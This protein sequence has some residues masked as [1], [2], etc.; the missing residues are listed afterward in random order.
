MTVMFA[1]ERSTL[2]VPYGVSDLDDF[3]DWTHAPEFPADANVLYFDGN[4][5]LDDSMERALHSAI[6]SAI[7][8]SIRVWSE[9]HVPGI[10]YI[11]SMRF[12]HRDADLS[13]EPDVIFVSEASL[14]NNEVILADGDAS[15]EVQGSPDIVVEIISASS[16][17]KDTDILRR[18]YFQAG[19]K[20]YWL[21]DSRG[22]PILTILKR[23]DSGFIEVKAQAGWISSQSLLAKCKL[24][25]EPGPQATTRVSLLLEPVT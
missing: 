7:S 17:N 10:V 18:K 21:A 5:L 11:D 1:R 14:N 4:I 22:V 20:E 23:S 8:A 15:L 2:V 9:Q 3:V 13:S 25:S 19:V 16:N 6:K 12:M 24:V